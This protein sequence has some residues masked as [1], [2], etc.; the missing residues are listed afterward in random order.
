[1]GNVTEYEYNTLND[2]LETV[3]AADSTAYYHYDTIGRLWGIESPSAT[4]YAF[5]YDEFGEDSWEAYE[6]GYEE[7]YDYWM[8]EMGE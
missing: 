8:D 6:Y 5:A 3:T 1:M 4:R 7:A 2:R